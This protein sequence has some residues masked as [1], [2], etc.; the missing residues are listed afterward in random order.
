[1]LVLQKAG[2]AVFLQEGI[3]EQQ[4]EL[5]VISREHRAR[6]QERSQQLGKGLLADALLAEQVVR[7]ARQLHD[8]R[9]QAARTADELIDLL[10]A[11]GGQANGGK[12]NDLIALPAQAARF[13]V[14]NED[15]VTAR[16]QRLQR[17]RHRLPPWVKKSSRQVPG[18]YFAERDR[19]APH[20]PARAFAERFLVEPRFGKRRR[21]LCTRKGHA[22]SVRRQ[23][24]QRLRNTSSFPNRWIGKKDPARPKL[25]WCGDALIVPYFS[26]LDKRILF[27]YTEFTAKQILLRGV[28]CFRLRLG[29]VTP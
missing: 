5:G 10:R 9:R 24:R 13:R 6:R 8:A 19:A 7:D 26:A 20:H 28:G 18:D 1:M 25:Q 2:V 17:I 27:G 23:S 11:G 29:E 22:A 21:T 3:E 16:E 4:I 15:G 12:F 14:E